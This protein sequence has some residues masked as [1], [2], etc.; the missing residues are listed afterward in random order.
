MPEGNKDVQRV[1]AVRAA[2]PGSADA[3]VQFPEFAMRER[4]A[5]APSAQ[6][7]ALREALRQS[8]PLPSDT[9]I[10]EAMPVLLARL[11]LKG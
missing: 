5:K 4:E 11:S 10:T 2:K 9:F 3:T 7:A 1:D 6:S 8:Y